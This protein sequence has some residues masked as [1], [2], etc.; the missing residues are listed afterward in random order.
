MEDVK[1]TIA[2]NEK[3]IKKS[4]SRNNEFYEHFIVPNFTNEETCFLEP[5]N[6]KDKFFLF[7]WVVA[8]ITG[9]LDILEPFIYY[10]IGN[11]DVNITKLVSNT[12]RYQM[13]YKSKEI[14]IPDEEEFYKPKESS[15]NT[16]TK[17]VELMAN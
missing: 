11:V 12:K 9:Y 15:D 1:K 5:T 2:T 16:D 7:V 8:F 4:Y 17:E 13:D 14:D 10:E 6:R 3:S